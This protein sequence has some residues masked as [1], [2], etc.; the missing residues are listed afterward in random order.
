MKYI[1]EYRDQSLV[2]GLLAAIEKRLHRIDREITIME[3]CGTHTHVIGRFGIKK[4]LPAQIRLISGPGCPVCV[5]SIHDVDKALY[6][7]EQKDSIFAT[8]GD[9][10][11]VP[12]THRESLQ[13]SRAAGAD[14]RVVSSAADCIDIAGKNSGREVIMMGIGFETT[15]PTVAAVVELCREKGIKNF[16]VFSAHKIVPPALKALIEDTSLNIDGFICPGHVSTIIGTNP[17][18]I[19]PEAGRAAVIT[20]F[21]PVDILEGILMILGQIAEGK[22]EVAVQ[23]A[24]GMK[25]EGNPRARDIMY[26]IFRTGDA[27]WRGLGKI[28][29]SGL[30]LRDEYTMYDAVEKFDIPPIRSVEI[31]GC[32][33]GDVLKG[34]ILPPQCSLFRKTCTPINPIGPCMV[35][36]E[37]TCAA[38]Y[39]YHLEP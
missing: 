21:E 23:Y 27:E 32:G 17:Y 16:S 15:A 33:C 39:K 20:G 14:I 25:S 31:K 22:K 13:K 19:I 11:R 6:L 28:P 4:L 24:R 3:I 12:G 34:V 10:L 35:S 38:Y 2:K 30:F 5:T 9:M 36:S 1:D 7:A 18:A 8:F 26:R 29:A 37:G